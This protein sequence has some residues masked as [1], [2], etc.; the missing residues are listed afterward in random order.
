MDGPT[1]G[2][3]D[4][5]MD[6]RMDGRTDG[7]M[8]GWTDGRIDGWMDGRA[9]RETRHIEA[10]MH[11]EMENCLKLES[12]KKGGWRYQFPVTQMT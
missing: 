7:G 8:D 10:R 2:W 11:L 4:G 3:M 12:G 1:D 6:K 9:D 5:W